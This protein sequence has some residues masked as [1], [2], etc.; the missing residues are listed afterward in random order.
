MAIGIGFD[1]A[2]LGL[3][4]AVLD[5]F[6]QGEALKPDFFR[7]FTFTFFAVLI[8]GGQVVLAMAISTGVTF[9]MTVLLLAIIVTAVMVQTFADPIQSGSDQFVFSGI[10]RIRQTRADLRLVSSALPR[11]KETLDPQSLNED[12]FAH[13]VRRAL[14]QMGN[15]PRLAAS[16]LTRLGIVESSLQDRGATDNT[17][18]RA[19]ELKSILADSIGKLKPKEARD[20]G[21]S[22]SWRYYN[23]LYYPYVVGLKSYSR[24]LGL[25]EL[26]SEQ[27][28]VLSWFQ[29]QVPE[30]TLHNWQNAAAKLVAQNIREL[31]MADDSGS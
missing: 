16:P 14:S 9:P 15:L 8:F 31:S 6:G 21:I 10:P 29:N 28:E 3:A 4:I 1:L 18:E 13:L 25:E 26:S 24:R 20:H 7:S 11:I 22:D 30:R 2:L 5:A 23:A 12:Q 19:A 27:Q 17:L